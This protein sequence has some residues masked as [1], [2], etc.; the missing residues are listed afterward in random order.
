MADIQLSEHFQLHEFTDSFI[1]RLKGLSNEPT[2]EAVERLKNLCQQVLEPLRQ[3]AGRPVQI[4]SGYR[5]PAVNRAVGGVPSSQHL[6]GEA[7]DILLPSLEVGWQWFC[8]LRDHLPYD[9]LIWETYHTR[10]WIHVS[11]K[12]EIKENRHQVIV[13]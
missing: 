11:C 10:H 8:Y 4:S 13:L 1:A 6:R 7:A 3:W 5:S 2:A 12:A 9:Q